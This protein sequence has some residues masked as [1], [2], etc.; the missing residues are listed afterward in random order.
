MKLVKRIKKVG[1][2][3]FTRSGKVS[4]KW[5]KAHNAANKAA[6]E[7]FGSKTAK[8]INKIKVPSNE[9]LGSHTR[10]GKIKVSAKVPKHLRGAI[11][12]HEKVEHKLMTSKNK[13]K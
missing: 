3:V 10:A 8:S 5:H 11:A 4:K 9:L 7:K 13:R 12:Y 2:P 6:R 1:W